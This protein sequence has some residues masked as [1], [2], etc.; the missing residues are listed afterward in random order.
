LLTAEGSQA[1]PEPSALRRLFSRHGVSSE[2]EQTVVYDATGVGAAKLALCLEL[3]GLT[4]VALYDGG[5]P[6]WAA[7]PEE[8][9]PVEAG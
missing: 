4:D 6:D 9:F 5:W 7:L 1:L 3:V 8:D 2:V